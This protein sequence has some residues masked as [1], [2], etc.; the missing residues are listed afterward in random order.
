[1]ITGLILNVKR[2]RGPLIVKENGGGWAYKNIRN[3][4]P[5]SPE[6]ILFHMAADASSS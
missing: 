2:L 4:F 3:G 6:V 5:A 1:M